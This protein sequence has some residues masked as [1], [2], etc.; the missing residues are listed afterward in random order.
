MHLLSDP[1]AS[2]RDHVFAEH[3]WHDYQAHERAA[4]SRRYLYIR[5]AFPRLPA[6]PPADAVRSPSFRAMLKL[7]AAGKLKPQ[8]RQCFVEVLVDAVGLEAPQLAENGRAEFHPGPVLR[9]L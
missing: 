7:E 8:Q 6:T 9:P 3:N 2:A 5:N 4:R 1:T